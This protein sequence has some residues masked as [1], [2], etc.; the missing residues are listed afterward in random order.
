MKLSKRFLSMALVLIFVIANI[1]VLPTF[2]DFSDVPATDEA[3]TAVTVLSKLGVINGYEDGTF[4]PNN[5]VTRAEFTA[6][7]LRTRG[8][9]SAG[10]DSIENP[11]FPDVT[12]DD[13]KWAI[14]NIRT[15]YKMG[16]IN[17]YSDGTFGPKKNVSYEEAVKMIVCALGYENFGQPG[18][19]WYSKYIITANTLGFLNNA[20]GAIGTP[21]TRSTI[22]RML[23]NCLEVEIAENNEKTEKTILENDL[24]LTKKTGYIASNA[25]T[26]LSSPDTSIRDDEIQINAPDDKGVYKTETYKVDNAASYKDMLGTEITFYY[27]TDRSSGTNTVIYSSVKNST[28]LTI[29]AK[30]LVPSQSN[31]ST[32]TYYRENASDTSTLRIDPS[33]I[34]IYN[35]KLYGADEAASKVS[36]YFTAMGANAVPKLG[37]MKFLD[38]D[39]NGTYDILFVESY[40]PYYVSSF[41]T[42]NYKVVDD[43]VIEATKRE[44]QLDPKTSAYSLSFTDETGKESSFS[45]IKKG[46]IICLK[47]SNQANGGTWKRVAVVVNK[48]VNGTVKG[49]SS[50]KKVTI[51]TTEYEYS[52]AA[53]WKAGGSGTLAAPKM[54]DSC[55]YYLDMFGN[56]IAYD[57][58]EATSNQMYGFLI[59]LNDSRDRNPLNKTEIKLNIL[60][61]S[62]S[63][64]IYAL[65]DHTKLNG[66]DYN[67]DYDTL[68]NDLKA[69]HTASTAYTGMTTGND[70]YQ[71]VKFT[72]STSKGSGY[73]DE[74][75]TATA[76]DSGK[77]LETDKLYYYTSLGGD[78]ALGY[79]AG[80]S[81]LVAAGQTR[82]V[83]T[84][85]AVVFLVGTNIND[86][87]NIKKV[88]TSGAFAFDGT[89]KAEFYDVTSSSSAK[90]VVVYESSKP[91][92][93]LLSTNMVMF[94]TE[95]TREADNQWEITGYKN[96]ESNKTTIK[97]SDKSD[98]AFS[99]VKVGDVLR[100]N[101]DD[102]DA[103]LYVL[104]DKYRVFSVENDFRSGV[105]INDYGNKT[106]VSANGG[107]YVDVDDTNS[108]KTSSSHRLSM[109]SNYAAKYRAIWGSMYLNDKDDSW[110]SVSGELITDNNSAGSSSLIEIPKNNFKNASIFELDLTQANWDS[111]DNLVPIPSTDNQS[112][113][114]QLNDINSPDTASEVFLYM[115]GTSVKMM[116]II[117]R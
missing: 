60:N 20:G 75:V 109:D 40:V 100:L 66:N 68:K 79:N 72:T 28:S 41:T 81:N 30:D 24:K 25:V 38:R 85:D 15:A 74:I 18:S 61:Q 95:M 10:S 12:T 29:D 32:I 106:T 94:V 8:L 31:A 4:L 1:T 3:Y 9:G 11:P 35:D 43:N 87:T 36:T 82:G 88:A 17:G 57:K 49:T 5:N 73:I 37:S 107:I 116:L 7:L 47:E 42:S 2:A 83:R 14:G 62:G 64:V 6:M 16:I 56:V 76:T 101:K 117:K 86:T 80:S 21:A 108:S 91:Q 105:A 39:G 63:K 104:E 50:N 27:S 55:T 78:T 99:S 70:Y 34:V 77:T 93:D 97:G 59:S 115:S 103:N 22:A 13:V 84:T 46:S 89:Y 102:D 111:A 92:N 58:T 54:G 33:G 44:I 52:S 69:A 112:A 51:N 71:V 113:I 19:E 45:A 65:H 67:G 23:Y 96:G 26:S 114:E 48:S 98:S 110:V 90:V 53:P